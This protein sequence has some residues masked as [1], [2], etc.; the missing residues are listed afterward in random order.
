[1]RP[2]TITI[3]CI[4]LFLFVYT[5]T[6]KLTHLKTFRYVLSQSPLLTNWSPILAWFIPILELIITIML[7]YPSSRVKALL[8]SSILLFIF[9]FYIFYMIITQSHLPCQC[10]G[11]ISSL[12]WNAHL[13][14]N[15][16]LSILSLYAWLLE[17]N[18]F[19]TRPS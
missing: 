13:I 18:Y 9:S 17:I 15:L 12:S 14:L 2:L 7:F 19:N 1:M 10:G 11:I 16:S 6:D 3:T 8:L 5:A 4:L